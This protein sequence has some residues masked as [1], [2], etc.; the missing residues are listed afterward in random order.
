MDFAT[1]KQLL[2]DLIKSETILGID[3]EKHC[4]WTKMLNSIPEYYINKDGR[5]AS[6]CT[7]IL[8]ITTR[9][10]TFLTYI[11]FSLEEK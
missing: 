3:D 6:G 8:K 11:P 4:V 10:G 5:Y 1:L 2:K 7:L 9:I